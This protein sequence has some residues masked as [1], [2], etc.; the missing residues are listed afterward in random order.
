MLISRTTKTSGSD[1]RKTGALEYAKVYFDRWLKTEDP[2]FLVLAMATF[3]ETTPYS[4]IRKSI[5]L[6]MEAMLA[7]PRVMRRMERLRRLR[8]RPVEA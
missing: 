2:E 3:A 1:A 6:A 7:T 5:R 4:P 8:P